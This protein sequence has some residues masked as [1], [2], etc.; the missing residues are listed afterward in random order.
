MAE[1]RGATFPDLAQYRRDFSWLISCPS[2]LIGQEVKETSEPWDYLKLNFKQ[3]EEFFE[4]KV[5]Y[6]VGYYAEALIN[7]WLESLVSPDDI[8]RRIQIQQGN[9]TVGELDF[10]YRIGSFFHH[11]EVALKFYLYCPDQNH[12]GSHLVGP[13]SADTFERKRDRLFQHQLPLGRERFS[14]VTCS[15]IMMKG[16]IFYPPV[17]QDMNV[18]PEGLNP[19]H[20]RGRWVHQSEVCWIE[21]V[22][23]ICGASLLEKPFW[24]SG[25][26][27]SKSPATVVRAVQEHFKKSR[28]PL[29]LSLKDEDGFEIERVFVVP[30]KWPTNS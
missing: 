1:L 27:N 17:I 6:R 9:K 22:P 15:E 10:L 29:L 23:G 18:S 24:L 20:R 8:K 12:T 13:N 26:P 16:M 5:A 2:L 3:A 21:T 25:I 14:E 7:V 4:R 19:E 28:H 11:L 30:D